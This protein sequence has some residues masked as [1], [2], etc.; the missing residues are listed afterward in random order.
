MIGKTDK[1]GAQVTDRPVEVPDLFRTFCHSLNINADHE[2]TSGVG[3]P[4]PIVEGG[5]TVKEVFG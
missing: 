2:N 3:R 4:V 5:T 1:T